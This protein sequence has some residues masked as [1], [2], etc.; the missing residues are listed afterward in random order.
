VFVSIHSQTGWASRRL[1]DAM[2]TRVV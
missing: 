2:K 1:I